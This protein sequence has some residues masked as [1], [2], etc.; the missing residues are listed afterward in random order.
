MKINNKMENFSG[1]LESIKSFEI[2]HS[3][4][5]KLQKLKLHTRWISLTADPARQ[6]SKTAG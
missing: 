6:E 1:E 4:N 2:G 5:S 3:K